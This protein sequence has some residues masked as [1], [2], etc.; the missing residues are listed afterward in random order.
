MGEVERW[1]LEEDA[2]GKRGGIPREKRGE[3]ICW[4][5]WGKIVVISIPAD[6]N[7][8]LA[9]GEGHSPIRALLRDVVHS[10]GRIA[11]KESHFSKDC[12]DSENCDNFFV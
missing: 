11:T 2:V 3:G 7:I 8:R 12:F 4:W 10:I 9:I 5:Q 6:T 1:L